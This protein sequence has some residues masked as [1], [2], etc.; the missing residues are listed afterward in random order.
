MALGRGG[1]GLFCTTVV[2]DRGSGVTPRVAG[3]RRRGGGRSVV[4]SRRWLI[5]PCCCQPAQGATRPRLGRSGEGGGPPPP[6][7]PADTR[8]PPASAP[9]R[10]VVYTCWQPPSPPIAVRSHPRRRRPHRHG[11]CVFPAIIPSLVVT[12]CSQPPHPLD[13]RSPTQSRRR[14]AVRVWR[15]SRRRSLPRGAAPRSTLSLRARADV[16][17]VC[18]C[19]WTRSPPRLASLSPAPPPHPLLCAMCTKA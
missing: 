8:R 3:G 7:L 5:G 16:W 6:L 17:Y 18:G 9:G 19:V 11:R 10:T 4:H 14:S 13:S 12:C 2:V 1:G 15:L